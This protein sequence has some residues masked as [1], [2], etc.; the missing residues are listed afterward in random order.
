MN[1]VETECGLKKY[2]TSS[3]PQSIYIYTFKFKPGKRD[4]SKLFINFKLVDIFVNE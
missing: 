3:L 2:N 1:F 4:F